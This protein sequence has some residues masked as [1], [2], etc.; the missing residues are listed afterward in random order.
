MHVY[1]P[2]CGIT[3]QKY[4][5]QMTGSIVGQSN[6]GCVFHSQAPEHNGQWAHHK[7]I[8]DHPCYP[9]QEKLHPLPCWESYLT[10]NLNSINENT[11]RKS[12][13]TQPMWIGESGEQI[14]ATYKSHC[15]KAMNSQY[16]CGPLLVPHITYGV[17][18]VHIS[19][20]KKVK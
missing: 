9:L 6:Q 2:I 19:E 1:I 5:M 4:E 17:V 10:H 11:T 12:F 7:S 13:K 20:V 15:S 3:R 14:S 16:A 8:A 18:I